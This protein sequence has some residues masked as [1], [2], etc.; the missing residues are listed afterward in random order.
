[1]I[2]IIKPRASGKTTELIK[3]CAWYGGYIVCKNYNM[4]KYIEQ[5]ARSM[6]LKISYPMTYQEFIDRHYFSRNIQSF[7]IDD[8]EELLRYMTPV[9]IK[10]ITLTDEED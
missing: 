6:N 9:E 3:L 1:M 5:K 4:V 7:Y 10:A 2:K 8:V